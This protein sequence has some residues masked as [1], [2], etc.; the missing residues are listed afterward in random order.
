MNTIDQ[1]LEIKQYPLST[2]NNQNSSLIYEQQGAFFNVTTNADVRKR[3]SF[4][5]GNKFTKYKIL[6]FFNS[7]IFF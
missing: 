6:I 3:F 4:K 2:N 5:T 7:I 1:N